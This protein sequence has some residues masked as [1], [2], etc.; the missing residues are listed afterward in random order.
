MLIEAVIGGSLGGAGPGRRF[1]RG[2]V[3]GALAVRRCVV[4]SEAEEACRCSAVPRPAA[5]TPV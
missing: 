2:S 3:V 5:P 4:G 1:L